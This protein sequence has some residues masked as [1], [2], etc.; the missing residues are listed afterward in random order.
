MKK[1]DNV[2]TNATTAF[3]QMYVSHYHKIKS[4]CNYYL[5]DPELSK[6]I[7]QDVFVSAWNNRRDLSFSNE[8]LPYL[9]VLA[10]NM[11]LNVL[12]REKV[13][14]NYIEYGKSYNRDILNYNSLKEP[15]IGILYG[16][17]MEQ[18]VS[19]ALQKM[20]QTVRSTFLLSRYKNL[21]YE[22]IAKTQNI[23]IKTVEYRIMYA[24]RVLRLALKDYL[25][26]LLGYLA[27]KL[28]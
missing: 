19:G 16:K 9:F 28:L 17:E 24:L 7:A 14:N 20:P 25:P 1:N 8:L 11:C 23:S 4:F 2:E 6:C 5:R 18:L 10:K 26:I 15:S 21:K 12:K 3:E 22:Q 27:M 13:K